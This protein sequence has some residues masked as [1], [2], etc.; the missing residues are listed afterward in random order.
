MMDN[1]QEWPMGIR[2]MGAQEWQ[3]VADRL[4]PFLQA[5]NPN[6]LKEI[7]EGLV[8]VARRDGTTASPVLAQMLSHVDVGLPSR[9]RLEKFREELRKMRFPRLEQKKH[10]FE[11]AVK[12]LGLPAGIKVTTSPFFEDPVV[13][14]NFKF[15]SLEEK[16]KIADALTQADF[17]EIFKIL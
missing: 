6:K 12:Q 4:A 16:K 17:T 3:A 15:A 14:V 9:E 5:L 13:D 2:L 8:D 11:K 10:D 7:I 1:L